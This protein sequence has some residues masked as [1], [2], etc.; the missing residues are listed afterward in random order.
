MSVFY[1]DLDDDTQFQI[2][3][4]AREQKISPGKLLKTLLKDYSEQQ[5]IRVPE[6]E[7]DE[8]DD[9]AIEKMKI[10]TVAII[11]P[12]TMGRSLSKL[13]AMKGYQVILIGLSQADLDD[14]ISRLDCNLASM[15]DKW[16]LTP[17]EKKV[18]LQAI[19]TSTDQTQVT[20]AQLV[21]ET[22]TE[23]LSAKRT[24]IHQIDQLLPP[25]VIVASNTS[26]L[27][28]TD[29]SGEMGCPQRLIGMHFLYP[30]TKRMVVELV[31]SAFTSQSV[32]RK[33]EDVV[34]S[35][36]KTAVEVYESPGFVTTRV[37]LPFIN[38]AIHALVEGVATA[39]GIDTAIRMGY[40]IAL[41]PLEL[42]D[43]I[44]LDVV[45]QQM[46]HLFKDTGDP[47]FRAD[48]LLRRMVHQGLLGKKVG[49]GFFTYEEPVRQGEEQA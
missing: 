11:G 29:L 9:P 16:E 5:G 22:I 21:I 8:C 19:R 26:S 33:A 12:G 49:R 18:I 15:I 45:L 46:D 25:H 47:K 10:N 36:G 40:N 32:Y 37:S 30:P 43:T 39:E 1:T 23:N 34:R 35:L 38:E 14:A 31:R 17:S 42:A 7:V 41:G 44:G 27:R 13:F 48:S 20:Q 3:Y 24:L 28:L 4:L 6:R 2:E